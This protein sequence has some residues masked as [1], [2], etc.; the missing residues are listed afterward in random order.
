MMNKIKGLDFFSVD[1]SI[2]SDMR[3]FQLI[4]RYGPLGFTAYIVMISHI[5]SKGYYVEYDIDTLVYLLLKHIPSK[6]ISGKN[7]LQEIILY[8]FELNLLDY[9]LFNQ[10]V[11]TSKEIQ[12]MFLHAAKKRKIDEAYPYWL[13]DE[14]KQDEIQ[15]EKSEKVE[16]E[17][18]LTKRQKQINKKIIDITEHAPNKHY[19]TSCLITYRYIDEYSLDI[20]KFNNLFEELSSNYDNELLFE[21]TR[22][23]CNYASRTKTSIDDPFNYFKHSIE[24]NLDIL[25]KRRTSDPN[26]T[27]SDMFKDLFK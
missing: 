14:I 25:V 17:P 23:L 12:E 26:W 9:T 3:I 15:E 13:I 5:Y 8:L 11:V 27:I 1:V 2:M 22:Y 20:H 18:K 4:K 6:F 10:G 21:A 19:L 24:Q 16:E 7:K